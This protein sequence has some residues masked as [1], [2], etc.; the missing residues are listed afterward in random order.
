MEWL[1]KMNEAV[2]YI[3][4]HLKKEIRVEKAAEKALCSSFNFQ[5]IFSYMAGVSVADYIRKRR[6]TLAA[7]E[8]L[9][10]DAKVID[11][12]LLFGYE[13]PTSFSRAFYGV[14]GI[15]PSDVKK[16][17][18]KIKSYSRISFE[19]TIKGVEAMNYYVKEAKAFRLIG[20]KERISMENGENFKRI[21]QMWDEISQGGRYETLMDLND[22]GE[23]SC[24]GVCA[25]VD[26]K[27]F[28]YYIGTASKHP[29]LEGMSELTIPAG[30]YVIFEC[31]GKLPEGQQKVWKR[32]FTEW[33]PQSEYQLANGPQIEW[34]SDGDPTCEEYLSRIWIPV[35]KKP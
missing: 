10:T 23:L 22:D 29:L 5:R 8:L 7:M 20:Y 26:G 31:V 14:H 12:A 2:Q 17:G 33:L 25:D 34:Y 11:V 19:I 18:V 3:E 13:S 32:I 21:P 4:D 15:N 30:T 24:L 9:T 6:L 27:M 28:D 35:I 1:G 16:P